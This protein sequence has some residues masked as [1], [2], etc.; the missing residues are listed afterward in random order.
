MKLARELRA[1]NPG[2]ERVLFDFRCWTDK[3]A[4]ETVLKPVLSSPRTGEG[5]LSKIQLLE[6]NSCTPAQHS[7][8]TVAPR[9]PQMTKAHWGEKTS[10]LSRCPSPSLL[11]WCQRRASESRGR[12]S[13][14]NKARKMLQFG[15]E[16]TTLSLFAGDVIVYIENN[17]ES[18]K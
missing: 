17:Q 7:D 18:T 11:C 5:H 8:K 10:T 12:A 4:P 6:K 14:G 3:V 13:R 15:N 9:V 2:A 1:N 16:E